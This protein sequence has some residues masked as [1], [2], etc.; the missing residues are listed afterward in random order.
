M[1]GSYHLILSPQAAAELTAIHEYISKDSPDNAARMVGRILDAIDT[2]ELF[3]HR[4][5]VEHRSRNIK[6]P[7]RSLPVKP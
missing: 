3:P 4:N 5:Q 6:H 1:P 2:L 7:V